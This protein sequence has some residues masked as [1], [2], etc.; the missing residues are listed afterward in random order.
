MMLLL[1]NVIEKKMFK[2]DLSCYPI[3]LILTLLSRLHDLNFM[4]SLPLTNV[5]IFLVKIIKQQ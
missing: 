1:E 2:M 3:A 5:L 4:V